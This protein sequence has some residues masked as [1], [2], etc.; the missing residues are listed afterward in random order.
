MYNMYFAR[1]I[2]ITEAAI[3]TISQADTETSVV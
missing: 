2:Q 3:L 1:M